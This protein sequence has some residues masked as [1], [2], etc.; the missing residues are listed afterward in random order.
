MSQEI[1]LIGRGVSANGH[2][3]VIDQTVKTA[4]NN[5]ARIITDGVTVKVEDLDSTNGT[6]VNGIR[7][8]SK[9]L[10]PGDRLT[11]GGPNGYPIDLKRFFAGQ[12]PIFGGNDT[13]LHPHDDFCE[14]VRRLEHVYNQYQDDVESLQKAQGSVLL[15]RML[16][17]M[18]LGVL[19]TIATAL[20]SDE[21][22]VAIG[23]GGG[24]MTVVCFLCAAAMANNKSVNIN[25]ER[26]RLTENFDL[27]F[28]CPHCGS[29]WK[30][31]TFNYYRNKGEC[32]M[33][34]KK[35]VLDG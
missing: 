6:Y 32:P 29:S 3:I 26:T 10:N 15:I 8:A 33:C 19:T 14:K 30:G 28:V 20:V 24:I 9:K 11:L 5:H 7:I 2:N 22:K 31:H 12:Q 35:F 34:H 18:V 16:P 23:I 1:I 27:E 25:R 13:P 4:S 21:Q 17:T